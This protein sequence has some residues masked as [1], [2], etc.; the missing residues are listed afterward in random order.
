MV[1]AGLR[2]G[3]MD[4][5]ILTLKEVAEYPKLVEVIAYDLVIDSNSIGFKHS[6]I[7][8]WIEQQRKEDAT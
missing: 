6:N 1:R 7:E 2:D 3:R 4:N 5:T 8:N